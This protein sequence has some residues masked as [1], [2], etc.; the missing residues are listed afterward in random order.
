VDD[1]LAVT[2][3]NEEAVYEID[4]N[5][6]VRKAEVDEDMKVSRLQGLKD[7]LAATKGQDAAALQDEIEDLEQRISE[8][9]SFQPGYRSDKIPKLARHRCTSQYFPQR[10]SVVCL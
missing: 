10:V 2:E 5:M 7:R 9:T 1:A 6:H 8:L 4:E 3:L